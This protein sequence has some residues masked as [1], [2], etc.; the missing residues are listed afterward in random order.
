MRFSI[1]ALLAL[2]LSLQGC[3]TWDV[4]NTKRTAVEQL[5]LSA[6]VDRALNQMDLSLESRNGARRVFLDAV[7]LEAED[8][9]YVVAAVR[10]R[11]GAAGASIADVRENA[12]YIAEI[13]AG[14][15]ATDS[16]TFLVGMPSFTLPAPSGM[17][18]IKTPELPF[19][20]K[21]HQRGTAKLAIHFIDAANGA[22]AGS[23]GNKYGRANYN[24]WVLFLIPF[25]TTDL[26]LEND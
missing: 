12:D 16:S 10:E 5:L 19:F 3:A 8:E 20:K 21:L 26:P 15:L 18:D 17:S 13:R 14:A 4:S 1:S 11:L 7:N 9:P 6:S 25:H 24:R 2:A 22:F 23:T